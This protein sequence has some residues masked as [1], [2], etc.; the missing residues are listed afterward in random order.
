VE[1]GSV[2][3]EETFSAKHPGEAGS[4]ARFTLRLLWDVRANGG[5]LILDKN[6]GTGTLLEALN[7]L[8]SHLPPGF[9]PNALPLSTLA[10]R[11]PAA[12]AANFSLSAQR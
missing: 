12:A 10:V 11:G 5:R 2:N 8:R 7:L 3:G 9:V 4:L 1:R 6:R